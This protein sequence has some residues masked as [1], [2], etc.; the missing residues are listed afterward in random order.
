MKKLIALL[1]AL[2][3]AAV[4]VAALASD[5]DT[6]P[7]LDGAVGETEQ[8]A[9][10][11]AAA[12]P[13]AGPSITKTYTTT[14]I[15]TEGTSVY[16]T[17]TLEFTVT[18]AVASFPKVTVGTDNTFAVSGSTNSYSIPVNV[19]DASEYGVAGKYHY[20]VVETAGSSQ[21]VKYDTTKNF[22][23]DVYVYY[24]RDAEGAT[25][26]TKQVVVYSGNETS[27]NATTKDDKIEN[28][29]SVGAL[30]VAKEITG[31][32]SDPNKVFSI[33]VTLTADDTVA[34][35]ITIDG[36]NATSV[37]G[38]TAKGWTNNT[39]TITFTAK[40][41]QSITIGNIPT[42]VKYTVAENEV[43]RIAEDTVTAQMDAVNDANAYYVTGE[44]TTAKEIGA[45]TAN[46]TITNKKDIS[47]PT[48]IAL[49]TLPYV[50]IMAVAAI[51][52]VTLVARKRKEY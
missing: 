35:D 32:L 20:T 9:E 10:V 34:N 33:T 45:T 23:V 25:A 41:G 8:N 3:L 6:I 39:R 18:P 36:T 48:G 1:L 7:E 52:A 4:N 2:L 27:E 26:L 43:T 24:T 5:A 11:A 28:K 16:P 46:E 44:V 42:G 29:Y 15:I 50:L 22:N 30:T 13:A 51:G 40:G 21:A 38:D 31:N 12:A 47:I 49:D 17:E 14:G 19:P 37:T